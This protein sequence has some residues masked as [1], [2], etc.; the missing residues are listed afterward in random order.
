LRFLDSAVAWTVHAAVVASMLFLLYWTMPAGR[1]SARAAAA[2][3][4]P[5]ALLW[6]V[7][8]SAF[9]LLVAGSSRYK[10]L[11]GPLAGAIVLLVWIYYSAYIV[12]FCGEIGST[13][14][15]RY[16]PANGKT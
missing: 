11:Y 12:I 4:V 13:L 7:L 3:A 14:Q 10:G 2:A 5:G 6:V 8:R 15:A 1:V 9:A 16:W